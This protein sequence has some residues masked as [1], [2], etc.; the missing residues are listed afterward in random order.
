M[1]LKNNLYQII[2]QEAD[3]ETA[4]SF[5]LCLNPGCFIYKAHFP[6]QPITPGVCMVQ[7]GKEL[8]EELT[9][10]AL[11][12]VFVKNVKFLSVLVPQDSAGLQFTIS[13]MTWSDDGQELKAQITVATTAETKAKISLVCRINDRV[14]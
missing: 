9:G 2:R 12:I 6:G 3:G 11:D 7:M 14:Y 1:Q 13:K 10:K 4:V 8:L 5:E